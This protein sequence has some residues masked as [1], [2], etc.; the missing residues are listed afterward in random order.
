MK[1]IILIAHNK[2]KPVLVQF[3]KEKKDWLW[4]RQLVATGL[5]AEFVEQEEF[6][7]PVE[8]VS[9]GK[10]GGYRELTEIVD[11]N[12]AEVVFF[13]RDPEISQDYEDEV[14]AFIRSCN[15]QNIPLA[16][17]PATAE[18][19]ILGLIKMESAQRIRDKNHSS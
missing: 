10:E 9:A 5:T 18:L 17:N 13:F 11:N 3:L 14:I 12:G 19:L 6:P 1:K 16:T 15:R 7:V 8:H 2:M 4:G